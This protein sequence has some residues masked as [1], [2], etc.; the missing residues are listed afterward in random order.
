MIVTKVSPLILAVAAAALVPAQAAPW[1]AAGS[2]DPFAASAIAAGRYDAAAARLDAAYARGDR[3]PEVLLNLAAVRL[4]T[5]DEAM[6]QALYRAVLAQPN[7]DMLTDSG[8][9]WSHDIAQR[10]LAIAAR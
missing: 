6:A 5:R 4:Q 9:A 7:A 8:T 2:V 1:P 10:G 3:S